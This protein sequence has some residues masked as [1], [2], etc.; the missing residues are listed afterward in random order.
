M[1]SHE[2]PSVERMVDVYGN[3]FQSFDGQ[4][5]L[6]GHDMETNSTLA[7]SVLESNK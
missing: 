3:K 6:E 7:K 5:V 4:C 1:K 2:Q